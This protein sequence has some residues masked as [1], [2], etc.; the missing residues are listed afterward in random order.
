LRNGGAIRETIA[1]VMLSA[2]GNGGQTKQ[3]V[4]DLPVRVSHWLLALCVLAAWLTREPRLADLHAAAGYCAL[5]LVAFRLAWGFVG[6]AHA[7]FSDFRFGPRAALGYL[8][9]SLKGAP[10]H[11]TG[12]NPA[13]SW[14]VYFLLAGVLAVCVTGVIAIGAMFAMGPFSIPLPPASTDTLREAHEWLAWILLAVIAVHVAGAVASSVLHHENL[15]AAMVNGRKAVHEPGSAEVP[16]RRGVALALALA[17]TGAIGLY[18][19]SSGWTSG[20]AA[21]RAQA[22]AQKPAPTPWAKECGG[23]HLAYVP[24]LLPQRSWERMMREQAE[25]FGEDLSLSSAAAK[26]L[27]DEARANARPS[28]AE[29]KLAASAPAAE[30]PQRIT[31]LRFW[32]RAHHDLPESAFR[33]PVSLGRH[34]CE[35]CHL[36]A[37]SGIFH[38]RMIQRPARES[39]L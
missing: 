10:R 13:G 11:Y 28:W 22:R 19:S 3:R 34:D 5:V 1:A 35:S 39:I 24:A 38:P 33:A 36:D 30:S 23:C 4:W 31:E 32:R 17:A 14:S 26:A 18:L 16:A 21:T 8:A 25:H 27:L 20:Y 12:H 6:T 9:D 15:V 7:R 2:S 29:W 37:A